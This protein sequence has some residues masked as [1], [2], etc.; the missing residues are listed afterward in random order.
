MKID[1]SQFH[2]AFFDESA[3]HLADM[4]RLL[5]ALDIDNPVAE[6]LNAIFRAAHSIK[7]GSG[8]FGFVEMASV[9]HA[10][11]SLLDLLR[12]GS[13][14]PEP[15]MVD[16]VLQSG[17]LLGELL[18]CYRAG[19]EIDAD[20]Q[21]ACATTIAALQQLCAG[22]VA[23]SNTA[24]AVATAKAVD[25]DSFGFFDDETAVANV[26]VHS[27]VAAG[28]EDFGFFDDAPGLN[29]DAKGRTARETAVSAAQ[30]TAA[31][32]KLAP[33]TQAS[34]AAAESASIRVSIEKTEQLINLV[35]ELV[36]TEAM[37]EQLGNELDLERSERLGQALS[38][39]AR[40]T[41]QL[42][43]AAMS[44]RM[45]PIGQIFSRFPRLVRDLAGKLG[46]QID[47]AIEGESTELDKGL[48]EKL[49]DPLTHI[50][51]NSI[52]HGI[53]MPE[54][55]LAVGKAAK[56]RVQLRAFHRGG[57][58]VV[59]IIDDGKGLDREKILAKARERGLHV[60][61]DMSDA[62]VWQLIFEPGFSTAAAIT[63]ISG[64]GVGMDVVRRNIAAMSGRVDID[65]WAGQGS[66]IAIRLPLTLAILDGML[67]NVGAETF[68]IPLASIVESLQPDAGSVSTVADRGRVIRVRGEYFP[69]V[70]LH[71]QINMPS[72]CGDV[73]ESIVVLLEAATGTF[74][75]QV[76][77]LAGQSQVV[78]KSLETNYRR[79]PGFSGATILGNGRVAMILDVDS[80]LRMSQ[81]ARVA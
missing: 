73:Y 59:E 58:I 76:D 8:I 6:D 53:E 33:A 40:N 75:L 43:E 18:G 67:V 65:S 5:V 26:A 51:R 1:T 35:G 68:V 7:G 64:R 78:I 62:D 69:L 27:G 57:N 25:D 46:K 49:V 16:A 42:Q 45:L 81:Q 77:A 52:D 28:G 54:E 61:D 70:V 55:R 12:K 44:L 10:L 11:E 22:A 9:T 29:D 20:M 56:G 60:S 48:I 74:A 24:G 47:L 39:L 71:E 80:I 19:A 13:V 23:R 21:T 2:Q 38:Q 72:R 41:R 50:V 79:V 37:L 34:K 66:R 14:Q 4:E 30:P 36:I 63:D 3:E 17:D 31:V 32:A 15:A